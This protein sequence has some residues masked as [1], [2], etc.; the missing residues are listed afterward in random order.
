MA[1][2]LRLSRVHTG[3]AGM[4][5]DCNYQFGYHENWG[6]KLNNTFFIETVPK[7]L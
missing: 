7:A 4:E 3:I 5:Q 6:A 1:P 2:D